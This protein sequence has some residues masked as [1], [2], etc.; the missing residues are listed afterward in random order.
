MDGDGASW[1]RSPIVRLG[2]DWIA[3][4]MFGVVSLAGRTGEAVDNG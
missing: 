4:L 2:K 1:K 3:W